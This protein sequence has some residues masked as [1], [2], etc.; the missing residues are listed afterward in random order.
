MRRNTAGTRVEVVLGDVTDPG[1]LA[2][3]SAA[4]V[5]AVVCNPPYVPDGDRGRRPRCAPIPRWPCSPAPTAWRSSRDVIARAA[6]LLRP[7]GVLALEH[8]DTH[9]A[10]VAALLAA[11]GRFTDVGDHA[12]STGRPRTLRRAPLTPV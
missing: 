10:A 2:E 4:A 5:D 7:G 8:D 1:L 6:E 12:T 11:D 3:L 9:A